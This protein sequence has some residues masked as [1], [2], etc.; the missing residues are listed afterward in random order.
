ML[1]ARAGASTHVYS[2]VT[3]GTSAP[4]HCFSPRL[5]VNMP[6]KLVLSITES[7][8]SLD[9]GVRELRH[10]LDEN[11][12]RLM[13][14]DACTSGAFTGRWIKECGVCAQTFFGLVFNLIELYRRTCA[15][16]LRLHKSWLS[17]YLRSLRVMF[18]ASVFFSFLSTAHINPVDN[19]LPLGSRVG[20]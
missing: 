18:P 14:V 7:T 12:T 11:K 5:N 19:S 2:S 13:Q 6:Y 1:L 17:T 8:I 3:S 16:S 20:S 9:S 4:V 15:R 10:A